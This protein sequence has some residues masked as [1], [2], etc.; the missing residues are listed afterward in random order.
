MSRGPRFIAVSIGIALWLALGIRPAVASSEA[1]E[2]FSRINAERSSRRLKVLTW[3]SRLA[4]IAEDHSEEMAASGSLH[5]NR[6]LPN[7]VS[8]WRA[9]GENVGYGPDVATVHAAFMESG[10]HRDEILGEFTR[11]GVGAVRRG[12]TLWVTEVFMLPESAPAASA[13]PRP[14]TRRVAR[15]SASPATSRPRVTEAPAAPPPRPA[16]VIQI[17]HALELKLLGDL[18]VVGPFYR[19]AATEITG[20]G[21][22]SA[23][24]DALLRA[25]ERIADMV[26]PGGDPA[27][28]ARTAR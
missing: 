14:A 8:G 2:L 25:A 19:T 5:H 4:A 12:D 20:V 9:L 15:P 28:W 17:P 11:A 18:V 1:S 16:P 27:T 21:D 10:P 26:L 22:A 24:A 6:D 13:Q 7:Q 23:P 3:D